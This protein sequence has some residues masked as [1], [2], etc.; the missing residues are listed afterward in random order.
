[1]LGFYPLP[2]LP[3]L[4]ITRVYAQVDG[5]KSASCQ[6]S[7]LRLVRRLLLCEPRCNRVELGCW[8]E[9][10]EQRCFYNV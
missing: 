6:G 5:S 3:A 10:P 2:T 8:P 1:M 7:G 9:H 4:A